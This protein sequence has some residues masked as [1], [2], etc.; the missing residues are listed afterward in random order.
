MPTKKDQT[1]EE[2]QDQKEEEVSFPDKDI[3]R[4]T[5]TSWPSNPRNITATQYVDVRDLELESGQKGAFITTPEG[6]VF[7]RVDIVPLTPCDDIEL[8]IGGD[9]G[10]LLGAFSIKGSTVKPV[11]VKGRNKVIEGELYNQRLLFIENQGK[12]LSQKNKG[13]L[14]ITFKGYLIEPWR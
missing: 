6:F 12:L 11:T 4:I 7:E 8:I 10:Q 9:D 1:S 13:R 5:S 14:A 2:P 3:S